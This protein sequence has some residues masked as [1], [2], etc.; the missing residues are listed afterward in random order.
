MTFKSILNAFCY[1]LWWIMRLKRET[2]KSE[3]L[4]LLEFR[5]GGGGGCLLSTWRSCKSDRLDGGWG[6]GP[7]GRL[8]RGDGGGKGRCVQLC[9]CEVPEVEGHCCD[10]RPEQ[11]TERV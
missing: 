1:F 7:S 2:K 5:R 6:R 4:S 9:T 3:Q 8:S 10:V 11:G